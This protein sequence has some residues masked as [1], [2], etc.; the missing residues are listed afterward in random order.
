MNLVLL[1]L[2][3]LAC[4]AHHDDYDHRTGNLDLKMAMDVAAVEAHDR[5]VWDLVI[6]REAGVSLPLYC[7]WN[8]SLVRYPPPQ[9]LAPNGTLENILE[10]EE[11][12][13]G[14]VNASLRVKNENGQTYD[15]LDTTHPQP[16][17]VY[18]LWHVSLVQQLGIAY[19]KLIQI[20]Y[21]IF[22]S[23]EATLNALKNG[24]IH[25]AITPWD[26]AGNFG[27]RR[28]LSFLLGCPDHAKG[29]GR[30]Y[31]DDDG[32]DRSFD[33]MNIGAFITSQA[34]A[35]PKYRIGALNTN[36]CS[37][38]K[39]L[40]HQS[41]VTCVET[42]GELSLGLSNGTFELVSQHFPPVT[43][44]IPGAPPS[45]AYYGSL[46]RQDECVA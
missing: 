9:S 34:T 17:G 40:Y 46:Y 25:M 11:I 44:P 39:S 14:Y 27:G 31:Y 3:V 6:A 28:E 26:L 38:Y 4:S 41:N 36:E 10:E 23:P 20:R 15:A 8:R 45:V 13:F 24:D 12:V 43:S 18:T 42:P 37:V 16:T 32:D 5:G 2:G 30:L 35:S 19:G 29:Q 7:S 1:F 33:N 22:D 21:Q